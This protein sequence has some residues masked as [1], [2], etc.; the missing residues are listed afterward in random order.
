MNL[1][2]NAS[3]RAIAISGDYFVL[4][5]SGYFAFTDILGD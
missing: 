1:K 3:G 4:I 2:I 5:A